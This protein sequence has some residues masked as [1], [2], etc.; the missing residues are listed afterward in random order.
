M[1]DPVWL[2]DIDPAELLVFVHVPKA[3]GTSLNSVL[4]QVYGRGYV[5]YHPTLSPPSVRKQVE[6][7]P[8]RVLALGAHRPYGFHESFVRAS[9]WGKP[10]NA[11]AKRR[12]RYVTVL[13]NPLQRMKSYYRFVTTFPAHRLHHDTKGMSPDAFFRHMDAI[14][15]GECCNLQCNLVARNGTFE[16]A[17]DHLIANYHAVG[18]VD[19]MDDFVGYLQTTLNWPE[20]GE[21]ERRNAS[22][23]HVHEDGFSQ[24]AIDWITEKNQEDMKLYQFAKEHLAPGAGALLTAAASGAAGG[25]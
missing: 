5:N 22:P 10:K 2:K 23:S 19:R 14:G 3:A 18:V 8:N 6:R 4:W 7:R 16:G 21:I 17:R 13:R 25:V 9:L 12:C 15:N 24:D 11:F 1:A 20:L